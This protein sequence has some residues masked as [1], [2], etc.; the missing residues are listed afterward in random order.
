MKKTFWRI[1][2]SLL[3]TVMLFATLTSCK[4]VFEENPFGDALTS[5]DTVTTETERNSAAIT[6]ETEEDLPEEELEVPAPEDGSNSGSNNS[7]S[8]NNGSNNN[9]SNNNGSNNN[10]SGGAPNEDPVPEMDWDGRGFNVLS[11][12]NAYAPNF[13]IVGDLGSDSVSSAVYK[14]NLLIEE[15]Y[16]VTIY[17]YGNAY[18]DSFEKLETQILSGDNGY[19]LAF[20]YRDDMAIAIASGYMKDLATVEYLNFSNEWYNQSTLNSMKISG[21]LFH[22][23]SDFSLIDKART[24]VLFYNRDMAKAY[25]LPDIVP[26]VKGGSWTVEKMHTYEIAVTDD[27]DG[28]GVMGFHDQ[29]GLAA[30]GKAVVSTFWSGLGNETVTV[31]DNG[32]WTVNFTTERSIYSIDAMRR[33]FD[34][35]ISFYENAFYDNS[36]AHNVFVGGRCLFLSETLSAIEKINPEAD[37]S[38]T[39][40]PNPK[41]DTAQTRYYATNDN[42]YCATFGIPICASDCDFSGFMVETLSWQSHTTSLPEY[43]NEICKVQNSYDAD[44]AEMVDL[45]FDSL[46]FDF[47]LLYG[48][49]IKGFR[50]LLENS[51]FKGDDIV[52]NYAPKEDMIENY[53]KSILDSIQMNTY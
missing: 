35:D 13:E 15:Q 5:R 39:V 22:M 50:G 26:M 53:I 47:G 19:D 23:V 2:C 29:W 36:D 16:N 42:T 9:G 18:E 48:K 12:Q 31:N 52:D 51:I 6:I 27:A 21:K 46:V 30:G 10:G 25:G 20:L 34:S 7:G 37:F 44:C 40:I 8:N 11:V 38:F 24:N 17:E 33:V 3:A 43:Y 32:T 45:V 41:Y 14:R 28:D 1:A 4:I 49:N